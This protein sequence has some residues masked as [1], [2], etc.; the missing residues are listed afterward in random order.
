VEVGDK[1][2]LIAGTGGVGK[3]SAVLA[4]KDLDHAAF[5]SDDIVIV[6]K[7]GI[8]FGNMAW[9]K[10]YGYNCEGN[11]FKKKLLSGRPLL[12]KMQFNLLNSID[13]S[14]TRRKISPDKLFG[15]VLNTG[16]K[17]TDVLY[18]FREDVPKI[19][20]CNLSLNDAVALSV[21]VLLAEYAIFHNHLFWE[22]YNSIASGLPLVLDMDEIKK[23]W[24]KVLSTAFAQINLFKVS[25][26][27]NCSHCEYTK[28]IK[29]LFSEESFNSTVDEF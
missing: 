7:D 21:E 27:L 26:P 4:L 22:K 28:E 2:V 16:N 10:I 14:R 18:L 15:K 11:N 24:I 25:I 23:N 5:I 13:P 3:S 29:R 1:V 6:S 17:L 20:V 9:P 19:K 8:V 12:D